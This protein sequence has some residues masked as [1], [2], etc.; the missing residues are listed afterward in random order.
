MSPESPAPREPGIQM[1][2][3]LKAFF[4]VFR[5]KR[6]PISQQFRP[7]FKCFCL[8]RVS[9]AFLYYLAILFEILGYYSSIFVSENSRQL[10][11]SVF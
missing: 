11:I 6:R 9:T 2:G 5:H 8:I 10:G 3:A 7:R 1:T 4:S